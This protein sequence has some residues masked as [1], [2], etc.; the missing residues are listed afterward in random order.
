[1]IGEAISLL[2]FR[3]A[4]QVTMKMFSMA[5][6]A[7]LAL[8]SV[9]D[10]AQ[11]QVVTAP[12]G[13]VVFNTNQVFDF[14]TRGQ[15]MNGM[16]VIVCL[17]SVGCQNKSWGA[18]DASYNGVQDAGLYRI[19][20]GRTEDTYSGDWRFDLWSGND[21]QSVTFSGFLGNTIFD[22][23]LPNP[24]T[25]GSSDG[26]DGDLRNQCVAYYSSNN[27]VDFGTGSVQY[28]NRVSLNSMLY[29]DIFETVFIDFT[30]VSLTGPDANGGLD[31]DFTTECLNRTGDDCR[32]EGFYLL[33][34]T[35]NARLSTVPEPS[36]YALMG[37]GLLG[38]FGVARRRNR[39]A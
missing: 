28:R 16:S 5:V 20:V 39:N 2:I 10:Q 8:V 23:T 36:T 11:A 9:T 1:M 37:A 25:P 34:D 19:R 29:G 21:L 3:R 12:P 4:A 14:S 27:C 26:L 13:P 38:I 30:K 22:R 18:L 24:G 32:A 15:D 7:A 31:N 6:G 17:S 35:D 33:M